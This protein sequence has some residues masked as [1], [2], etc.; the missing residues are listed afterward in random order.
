MHF[1]TDNFYFGSKAQTQ[2]RT[3][4]VFSSVAWHLIRGL[5][6]VFVKAKYCIQIDER[7]R[8][9]SL[10]PV[11]TSSRKQL[12]PEVLLKSWISPVGCWLVT[13]HYACFVPKCRL[14]ESQYRCMCRLLIW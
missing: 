6:A 13:Q 12:A 9:V 3:L 11:V 2:S 5:S 4:G 14:S 7:A 1:Y 8:L 10:T